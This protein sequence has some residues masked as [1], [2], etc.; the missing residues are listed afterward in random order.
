MIAELNEKTDILKS[1]VKFLQGQPWDAALDQ[2]EKVRFIESEFQKVNWG[3][4]IVNNFEQWRPDL[5]P[6]EIKLQQKV[7]YTAMVMKEVPEEYDRL[8]Q[9]IRNKI[10]EEGNNYQFNVVRKEQ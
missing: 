7:M 4:Q 8:E 3:K 9:E 2:V 6:V 1:P 10:E 5:K